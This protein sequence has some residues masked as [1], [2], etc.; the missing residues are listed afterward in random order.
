MFPVTVSNWDLWALYHKVTFDG[1]NRIIR[2]ND[3][4]TELDI[5]IDIYSDWKEWVYSFSDNAFWLPA[6]RAIGG[7]PTVTGQTAGDIY[8]LQNGWKLYIDL[9]KVKVTGVLF[10]DDYESAYYDYSGNIQYPAQ[11]SSLVSGI[12]ATSGGSTPQEVWEYSDRSLTQAVSASAPTTAEIAQA[13]W[14]YITRTL[15]V[16]AGTSPAEIWSYSTRTLTTTGAPSASATAAA[17]WNAAYSSY[18]VDGTFGH[19]LNYVS[20]LEKQI[21]VNTENGVNGNGSQE[22]PYNNI[23]DAKTRAEEDGIRIINLIGD[24]QL[25]SS[26]KNF[27][28]RGIGVPEVD[29]NGQDI[30]NSQFF[31]CKIKGQFL[32][33]AGVVIRD[34]ILLNGVS[35]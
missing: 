33:G 3:G 27:T 14:E 28:I 32:N 9:T 24:I 21:W 12:S 16:S 20:N 23:G 17:V 15:T 13:V 5:K 10:S 34:S 11:V 35:N 4:V 18:D 7:D 26:F 8:F 19:L 30:K 2:V 25:T 1:A 31:Q 22:S 29:F 6:V